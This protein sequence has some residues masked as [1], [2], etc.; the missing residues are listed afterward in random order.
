MLRN[1]MYLLHRRSRRSSMS[2]M[3]GL[4]M[5]KVLT[6]LML[7]KEVCKLFH[8]HLDDVVVALLERLL[9]TL[10]PY[11]KVKKREGGTWALDCMIKQFL[12]LLPLNLVSLQRVGY[13]LL[14]TISIVLWLKD[15]Y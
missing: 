13:C 12:V 5:L 8:F 7:G 15:D 2:P 9:C 14:S 11:G 3:A 6:L 10:S 4:V 1:L